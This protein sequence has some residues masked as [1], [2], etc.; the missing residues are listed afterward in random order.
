MPDFTGI[1]SC[2]HQERPTVLTEPN[3]LGVL[4]L[5][6]VRGVMILDLDYMDLC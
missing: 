1:L 5:E 4:S 3:W 6:H 2:S